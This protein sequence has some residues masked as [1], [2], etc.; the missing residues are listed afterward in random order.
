MTHQSQPP[1]VLAVFA[2]QY[3]LLSF[4]TVLIFQRPIASSGSEKAEV[5]LSLCSIN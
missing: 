4:F 3:E 5:K 2:E 1:T